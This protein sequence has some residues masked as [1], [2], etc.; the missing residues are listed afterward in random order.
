MRFTEHFGVTPGRHD[1]WYDPILTCDTPLFVD[2]ILVFRDPDPFWNSSKKL[3]T[4]FFSAAT[5]K[6]PG[7]KNRSPMALNEA[8]AFLRFPE[9]KEF[10]LGLAIGHPAGSGT[11][12]KF[13]LQIIE[14]LR[15]LRDSNVS[16][17][18]NPEIFA[19]LGE[20]FGR[21][22]ISDISATSSRRSSLN[23]H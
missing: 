7:R 2:P 8:I 13:A 12:E 23:I 9:P 4:S 21:D 22:R 19:L 11:G 5:Q 16:S 20:G 14:S 10:A 1:D 3:F 18:H 17:W 15:I 6:I